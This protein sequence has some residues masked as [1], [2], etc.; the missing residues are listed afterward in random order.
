[1]GCGELVQAGF[2]GGMKIGV[3]GVVARMEGQLFDELPES[4]DE[5]QVG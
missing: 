2:N 1:M 3:V 4:L 5:I